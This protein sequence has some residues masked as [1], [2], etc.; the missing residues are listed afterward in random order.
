MK[1]V[2]AVF[3]VLCITTLACT[4]N[5]EN[6]QT[7]RSDIQSTNNASGAGETNSSNSQG[8]PSSIPQVTGLSVN[9]SGP[10]EIKLKWDSVPNATTYWIYSDRDVK[11]IIPGT[12]Y[13]DTARVRSATKYTYS[14][15]AVVKG[16]LGPKSD[17]INV[18]TPR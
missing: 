4:V 3:A 2:I 13:T 16:V 14:I 15:A 6:D 9:A 7:N 1:K 18:L 8:T 10:N 11:A 12:N 5:D 17:S